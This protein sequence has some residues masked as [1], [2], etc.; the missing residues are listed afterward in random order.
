MVPAQSSKDSPSG[1][2]VL[3]EILGAGGLPHE[4]F[5]FPWHKGQLNS[6]LKDSPSWVRAADTQPGA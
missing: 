5:L 2:G 3:W 1:P 4:G 6:T